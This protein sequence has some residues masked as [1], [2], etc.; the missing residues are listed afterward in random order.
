MKRE[1]A[2]KQNDY[3]SMIESMM[4]KQTL[5]GNDDDFVD[6]WKPVTESN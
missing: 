5:T 1:E 3:M 4:A 6:G 2:D